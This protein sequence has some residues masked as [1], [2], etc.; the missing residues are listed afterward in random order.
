LHAEAAEQPPGDGQPAPPPKAIEKNARPRRLRRIVDWFWR[1][2]AFAEVRRE[3][4]AEP[5]SRRESTAH[6]RAAGEL[7]ARA[8]EGPPET[9]S[10]GAEAIANELYR[11][12]IYW[13]L[14]A[15]GPSTEVPRASADLPAALAAVDRATLVRAAGGERELA[16]VEQLLLNDVELSFS[17]DLRERES[18]AVF[19]LRRFA[20]QLLGE[21]DSPLAALDAI[22]LQRLLRTGALFV[23]VV[24]LA[25]LGLYARDVHEKQ[26]DLARGKPW[27][28]SSVGANACQSPDQFCE[29]TPAFFFHTALERDPWVEIDFGAPTRF[30]AVRVT[31]RLDCCQER[32]VPLVLDVSNDE[33]HWRP[34]ARIDK[35]FASWRTDVKPQ[36]ARYLRARAVGETML[37][38]HEIRVFP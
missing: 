32:A 26:I 34:I 17:G 38:L 20:E 15:L 18:R 30:S 19:A 22:W 1:G 21:L 3:L 2:S 4:G 9:G 33:K 6:A 23:F 37:H 12:S 16:E 25:A 13:S 14:S 36:R 27:R 24:A 10:A 35:P 8:L 31:N 5:P 7:A 29:Q 11:Q 28:A